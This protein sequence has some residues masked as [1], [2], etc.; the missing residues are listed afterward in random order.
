MADLSTH[1]KEISPEQTVQNVRKFFNDNGFTIKMTENYES[2]SSTWFCHVDLYLNDYRISGANGKGVSEI[3]SLA[4]GHAELYERFCNGMMFGANPWW[5]K[6]IIKMNQE[7]HGYSL[8]A[9]E[10]KLTYD[11][12]SNNAGGTTV[13]IG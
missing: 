3:Y 6:S 13:I 5:N 4:S 12:V 8:R 10:K 9:D 7:K 11:E 2:E 1:Y